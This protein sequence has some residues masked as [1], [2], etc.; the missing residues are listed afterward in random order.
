M[1]VLALA[2]LLCLVPGSARA[3]AGVAGLLSIIPGLGQVYDGEPLEGLA[4]FTAVV[5]S[6]VLSPYVHIYGPVAGNQTLILQQASWDLW[7]YNQYDA[8]RD[9]HPADHRYADDSALANYA[10]AFNPLNVADLVTAPFLGFYVATGAANGD[11]EHFEEP[12]RYPF[13]AFVGMG[14]EAFFRG[15]LFPGFSTLFNSKFAGALVSTTAFDFFHLTNGWSDF[16]SNFIS[17]FVMGLIFCWATDRN[18]YDLR[19]GIFAHSM[20]DI[21]AEPDPNAIGLRWTVP[22]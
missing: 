21:I 7:L 3:S 4:W 5:G 14:E 10:A 22:F 17:R 15:Y 6:S 9:A 19:H 20:I 18:N 1:R 11:L 2:L 16:E 12:A 13:F 8:Y